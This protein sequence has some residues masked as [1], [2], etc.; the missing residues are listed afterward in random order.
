MADEAKRGS[1]W[2]FVGIRALLMLLFGLYAVVF[3][4][5]AL[6]A[7]VLVGGALLFVDGVLGLWSHTFGNAKTGNYWFDVVRSALAIIAGAIILISPLLAT[8]FTVTFLVYM[9]AFQ[10]LI[11]GGMEVYQYF[12]RR[13]TVAHGWPVLVSGIAYVL[14]GIMLV[15]WPLESAVVMVIVG[16]IFMIVFSFGLFG[17][18]WR[19]RKAGI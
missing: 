9:V 2:L 7:L 19:L 10:A 8:I 15:F 13:G 17:L 5:L 6:A 1:T 14:F 11:V 12:R 4:A 3:P 18:A 16:G